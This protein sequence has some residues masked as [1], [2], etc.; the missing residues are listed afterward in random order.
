MHVHTTLLL[1]EFNSDGMLKKEREKGE[2]EG[3]EKGQLE[4]RESGRKE[5]W[6]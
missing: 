6:K 5:Q 3:R 1:F 4:E 2:M